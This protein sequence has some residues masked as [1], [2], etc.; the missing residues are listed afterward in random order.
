[1]NRSGLLVRLAVVIIF[2]ALA[3]GFISAQIFYRLTY[4][5]ELEIANEEIEQLHATVS[6]TASIAAYLTDEELAKEVING[7]ETNGIVHGAKIKT[8]KMA[9]ESK[10][11]YEDSSLE[12]DLISPFEKNKKVGSLVIIPDFQYIQARANEIGEANAK[13]LI[14]Q[15]STVTLIALMVAYIL[16]TQPMIS[17]ASQLHK[18][19]PGTSKRISTPVFHE[20]SELGKLVGDVNMLLEKTESQITEERRLRREIEVL[21]KRFRMLFENSVSPIILLEPRGSILLFNQAFNK[22]LDKIGFHF[23][24]NFGPLL[25]ELLE[26]PE[27]LL[28]AVQTSFANEE[29]ATGEYKLKNKIDDDPKWV[30]VVVTS[31]LSDDMKEYY[32]VTLHDVSKRKRELEL[33]SLRADYDQLTQLLNRHATEKVILL[34]IAEKVP[35]VIILMDLDGFKQINDVYGHEAGDE[36]LLNVAGQLK[37]SVRKDDIA[38]RWGG[39]EFVI[40]LER[41]DQQG[42]VKLAEKLRSKI[43]KPYFLGKYNKEVAVGVSMGASFYPQDDTNMQKLLHLADQAMYM[44]K[45]TNDINPEKYLI[46]AEDLKET[47]D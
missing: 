12:F 10:L 40:V 31:I 41:V 14:A 35:F 8:E 13:A 15:A 19:T 37:R 24:K 21:E 1:M 7:L 6:A 3:V 25:E 38:C 47:T 4:Q 11:E 23:K 39:D 28:K 20:N 5:N 2:S 36:I 17:I 33:L 16:I 46:F 22:M 44:V 45:K 34:N 43:S 30:Q 42:V 27:K 26:E 18:T 9:I 32:Q 29:I